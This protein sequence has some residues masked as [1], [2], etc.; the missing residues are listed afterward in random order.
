MDSEKL[1]QHLPTV[2][3]YLERRKKA[4]QNQ[5]PKHLRPKPIWPIFFQMALNAGLLYTLCTVM[6]SHG[7]YLTEAGPAIA[8]VVCFLFLIYTMI[9]A[10]QLKKSHAKTRGN[11]WAKINFWLMA[12]AFLAWPACVAVY[13]P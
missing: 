5:L 8:M 13:L 10:L 7:D 12:A 6:I 1:K 9:T 4:S 3:G 11:R 2:T